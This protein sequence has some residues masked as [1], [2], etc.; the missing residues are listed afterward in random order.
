M[1]TLELKQYPHKIKKII[2]Q[3]DNETF[4]STSDEAVFK[5][6]LPKTD[7]EIII[8]SYDEEGEDEI[9][10]SKNNDDYY[11]S[12]P[13]VKGNTIIY[14]HYFI[15]DLYDYSESEID[16]NIFAPYDLKKLKNYKSDT[17]HISDD[18]KP[19]I[20]SR[21]QGSVIENE[22]KD[23]NYKEYNS[24]RERTHHFPVASRYGNKGPISIENIKN[25]PSATFKEDNTIEHREWEARIPHDDIG[26]II[27]TDDNEQQYPINVYLNYEYLPSSTE[28]HQ[29]FF[30]FEGK[31]AN[32]DNKTICKDINVFE[33]ENLNIVNGVFTDS[34]DKEYRY[35]LI[36]WGN[37]ADYSNATKV[38]DNYGFTL[39][40]NQPNVENNDYE[41]KRNSCKDYYI[42]TSLT[43]NHSSLYFNVELK[44]NTT[45]SLKYF[46]Y[47]P[48][49][50]NS[51]CNVTVQYSKY[52]EETNKN[53]EIIIGD[54][55][56]IFKNNANKI[57]GRW[58]YHEVPFTTAQEENTICIEG[59]ND[60]NESI[61]FSSFFLQEFKKYSPVIKY[62]N[63]G[64]FVVE[65]NEWA[66]KSNNDYNNFE[67]C[68]EINYITP[69]EVEIKQPP[70]P[71]DNVNIGFSDNF[72]LKYNQHSKI[73]SYYIP[74]DSL[75]K[76]RY[77]EDKVLEYNH[78]E[79]EEHENEEDTVIF[80]KDEIDT[81]EGIVY[82]AELRFQDIA[83]KTFRY[84]TN[85]NFTIKTFNDDKNFITEGYTECAITNNTNENDNIQLSSIKYLGK[86]YA[87]ANGDIKY[88]RIDFT[89]IPREDDSDKY[90]CIKYKHPCYQEE[91]IFFKKVKFIEESLEM[92]ILINNEE[93]DNND[94][95]VVKNN[96]DFP[97]QINA[98]I[99]TNTGDN[100]DWGYC[101]LSI[102]DVVVQT[103][104]V[105]ADGIADFY[106]N[107]KANNIQDSQVIKIEYFRQPYE[108]ALSESN[109][110]DAFSKIK[111]FTLELGTNYE[112]GKDAIP[113]R[114]NVLN[115]DITEQTKLNTEQINNKYY[116]KKDDC[117]LIDI[118]IPSIQEYINYSIRV[119]K[120][121]ENEAPEYITFSNNKTYIN[122]TK[123]SHNSISL[124]EYLN[125]NDID[126]DGDY[127][128]TIITDSLINNIN[129]D[130]ITY[131]TNKYRQYKKEIIINWGDN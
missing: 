35:R 44:S 118:D 17:Y 107:E 18:D 61:Y 131:S 58:V 7:T 123:N 92:R 73:L 120:N 128:Y 121:K 70:I 124:L 57:K 40:L 88:T 65:G 109:E 59:H 47:K 77:T 36:N 55:N 129:N 13:N 54:I 16:G 71:Y 12:I 106:L 52:N 8:F 41:W 15:S 31:N 125:E 14:A 72:N 30:G 27:P 24:D 29:H 63:Q 114:C 66:T 108:N 93:I 9:P 10:R 74:N 48:N 6:T 99:S 110:E 45:Y 20:T 32:Y 64:V 2:I 82:T 53:E 80:V 22:I 68:E 50:V 79:N 83:D 42:C 86:R 38:N 19:K 103:S 33:G 102:D 25:N 78:I 46:T 4:Q 90:L 28:Y 100:T 127:V 115:N 51:D 62:T 75:A 5:I 1:N 56:D 126:T 94:K 122:I 84:G 113:I 104:Y 60:E 89:N 69:K 85:N 130:E 37:K 87:D 3:N 67:E 23:P 26:D 97:L 116:I 81:P 96:E 112:K 39:N 119:S 105:G 95:Y 76:I 49:N 11:L 101:E 91:T 21:L 117:L 111:F 43:G 98:Y 34:L